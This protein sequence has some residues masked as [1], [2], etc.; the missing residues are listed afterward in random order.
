MNADNNI[1]EIKTVIVVILTGQQFFFNKKKLSE[2]TQFVTYF[3][4]F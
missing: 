1:N 2:K 4:L 3:L